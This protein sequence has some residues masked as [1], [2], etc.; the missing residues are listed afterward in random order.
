MEGSELDKLQYD[1]S[2]FEDGTD[3]EY[4]QSEECKKLK[5]IEVSATDADG[6]KIGHCHGT[7]IDREPIRARFY[8]DI[9]EPT[10]DN[11][12]MG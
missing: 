8:R 7:A 5:S 10:Q 2:E 4:D 1:D 3:E 6:K 9:E 11:S 12:E